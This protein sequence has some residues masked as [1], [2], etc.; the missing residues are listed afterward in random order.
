MAMIE[1]R[2]SLRGTPGLVGPTDT[3]GPGQGRGR[4]LPRTQ[5]RSH[6]LSLADRSAMTVT[7]VCDVISFDVSEVM[8]ETDLGMLCIR[9]SD[10]HVNRLTLEK[11]EVDVNGK[12][13]SLT[14][15]DVGTY[16]RQGES[17]LSRLFR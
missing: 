6:K 7:G 5:Q 11:G 16:K 9:G 1:E 12:I 4:E 15:S 17:L 13:D 14:Y 10:L 8:L 2:K 3:R